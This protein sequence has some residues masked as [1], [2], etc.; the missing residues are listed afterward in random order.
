MHSRHCSSVGT[1]PGRAANVMPGSRR[2]CALWRRRHML[3]QSTHMVVCLKPVFGTPAVCC[4]RCSVALARLPASRR[5]KVR[6]AW[7]GTRQSMGGTVQVPAA[8]LA[9]PHT[10]WPP[11]PPAHPHTLPTHTIYHI[12]QPKNHTPPSLLR[13]L[14]GNEANVELYVNATGLMWE[15][16][17]RV[18]GS[19]RGLGW[20]GIASRQAGGCASPAPTHIHTHTFHL[21]SSRVFLFPSSSPSVAAP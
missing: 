1:Q 8:L 14:P 2:W 13:Y 3:W 20:A 18:G 7:A 12:P 6:C 11:P 21:R 10:A 17:S 16:V 19:A 15:N 4:R 5:R 9:D